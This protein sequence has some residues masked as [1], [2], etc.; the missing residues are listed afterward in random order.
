M[1]HKQGF[2]HLELLFCL[3]EDQS[4]HISATTVNMDKMYLSMAATSIKFGSRGYVITDSAICTPFYPVS[5]TRLF[6]LV[7]ITTLLSW[8]LMGVF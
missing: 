2:L 1:T 8:N 7:N 6:N 3:K 4:F 5:V